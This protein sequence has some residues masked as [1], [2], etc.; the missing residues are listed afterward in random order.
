MKK[1]VEEWLNFSKIDL[2]SAKKL[3]EDEDL[4]QSAA[5]HVQ[6]SIEKSLKAIIE[7]LDLRVPRIHDLEKLLGII[8]ENNI[9]FKSNVEMISLIND[10][11][12]ETRYP[13]DQGLMPNGI[14]SIEFIQKIYCFAEELYNE[15]QGE[16]K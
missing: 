4:T 6:Q 12:I 13:G 5:F 11:Y 2:L 1:Q 7:N 3:L 15:I 8:I 16:K 10:I 9:N 14:P